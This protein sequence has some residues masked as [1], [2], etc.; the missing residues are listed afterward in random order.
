M[1]SLLTMGPLDISWLGKISAKL[2]SNRAKTLPIPDSSQMS[3]IPAY[4][5]VKIG[6]TKQTLSMMPFED[7][8]YIRMYHQKSLPSSA[9]HKRAQIVIMPQP[10]RKLKV[11]NHLSKQ[12]SLPLASKIVFSL[13]EHGKS[14]KKLA[15]F[16]GCSKFKRTL[17]LSIVKANC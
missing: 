9:F 10:V 15:I 4:M 8:M 6:E 7:S 5:L 17:E 16:N 3:I 1:M 11:M 12:D 14:P 13:K 2:F